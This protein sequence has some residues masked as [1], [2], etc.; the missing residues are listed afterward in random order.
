M[1]Y[2]IILNSFLL[3]SLVALFSGVALASEVT[4]N[5]SSVGVTSNQGISGSLA[6]TVVSPPGSGTTG[7]S[8]GGS[9][10]GYI[11]SSGSVLG[12]STVNV[13]TAVGPTQRDTI[14]S[15]DGMA[16]ESRPATRLALNSTPVEPATETATGTLA[17]TSQTDLVGNVPAQSAAVGGLGI[18]SW[19]WII[20]LILIIL[21]VV[22][23]IYSRPEKRDKIRGV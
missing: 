6:G 20:L 14:F 4:G 16:L 19:F 21:A 5:L 1:N 22:T 11:G 9:S 23:Y 10:G 8:S 18:G 2:K 17:Q 12:A 15:D 7:G 3:L 13:K